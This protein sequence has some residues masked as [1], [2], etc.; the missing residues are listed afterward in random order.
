MIT[1]EEINEQVAF[2]RID[3]V[4]VIGLDEKDFFE[5]RDCLMDRF[6]GN[7]SPNAVTQMQDHILGKNTFDYKG[8]EFTL[9]ND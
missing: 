6:S 2:A 4:S 1:I 7:A 3:N 5:T 9:I 8:N